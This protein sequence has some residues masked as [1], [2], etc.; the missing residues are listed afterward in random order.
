MGSRPVFSGCEQKILQN[1]KDCDII[2]RYVITHIRGRGA[3]CSWKQWLAGS[4]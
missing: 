3:R 1:G 2:S 4:G